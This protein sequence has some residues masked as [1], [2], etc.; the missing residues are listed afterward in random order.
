MIKFAKQDDFIS[1]H[2]SI[3][4]TPGLVIVFLYNISGA[5]CID[6]SILV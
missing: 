3:I 5:R 6:C 2:V 4:S 1:I